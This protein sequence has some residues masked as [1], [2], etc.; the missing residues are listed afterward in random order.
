MEF[1]QEA[2]GQ[3][4]GPGLIRFNPFQ[5][6]GGVS[7]GAWCG[8]C[9][10][11]INRFQSLSGFWWSF[12]RIDPGPFVSFIFSFQSLSGFWWS[13]C[14]PRGLDGGRGLRWGFNPFQGFGG[15]SAGGAG[16]GRRGP[17][18][19]F[20]PFQ[21]FGGVSALGVFVWPGWPEEVSIPF[22]VLVEFLRLARMAR[23]KACSCAFQSLSG[24][25]WSFCYILRLRSLTSGKGF[26]PF[27]GFGGVSASGPSS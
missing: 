19:G 24:F 8:Y 9:A 11:L 6:F 20:N 26:N 12:C 5:G 3:G 10:G 17:P 7:A 22:R 21:G 14:N 1:L 16:G 23:T 2:H 27:Q 25:W 18:G 13:F 4:H 15:V